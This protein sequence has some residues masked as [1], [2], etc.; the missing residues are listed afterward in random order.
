[1]HIYNADCPIYVNSRIIGLYMNKGQS[2]V[3]N[4]AE[5]GE[6]TDMFNGKNYTSVGGKIEIPSGEYRSVLLLKL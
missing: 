2:T 5:D 6:Y 1:M 4:V 3:V